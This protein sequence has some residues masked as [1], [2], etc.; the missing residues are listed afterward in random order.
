MK[1]VIATLFAGMALLGFAAPAASQQQSL[2]FSNEIQLFGTWQDQKDPDLETTNIVM[3]YGR[4][5][6]PQL[7]GTLGLRYA[8]TEVPGPD[9][10]SLAALIGAK[11]YFAPLRAQAMVPFV[12][13]AVGLAYSD[14]GTSDSTDL[15]WEIGGGVSWFFTQSTSFDAGLRLFHTDTDV[16]TKG[17]QIFVGITTRF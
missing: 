13:G 11:Y 7:V 10:S 17:T 8:H 1:K 4:F 5:F 6:R 15:T 12:E 2:P 14:S 16:E 9:I 3:R